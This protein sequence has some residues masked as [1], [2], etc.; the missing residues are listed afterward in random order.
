[1][2]RPRQPALI[3]RLIPGKNIRYAIPMALSVSSLQELQ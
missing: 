2:R 1:M 3:L